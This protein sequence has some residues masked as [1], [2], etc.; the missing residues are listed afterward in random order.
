M[1]GTWLDPLL[2]IN[3][4]LRFEHSSEDVAAA[5]DFVGPVDEPAEPALA[6]AIVTRVHHRMRVLPS[7]LALGMP[8]TLREIVIRGGGNCVSHAVLAAVLLRDRGLPTRLIVEDVY[9]NVSLLRAPAALLPARVGPTLNGHVWI[10]VCLD[11]EWVPADPE[12]G[13]FGIAEWFAARLA[14]GSTLVALGIPV[15][16]HWK[17][18]LRIR[19]LGP[20]GMPQEDVTCLHLI[21][22]LAAA[23]GPAASL[24]S[25]W[26]EGVRYFSGSC[27]W[28]GWAGLR[29]LQEGRRLRQMTRALAAFAGALT[30]E[31]V[32]PQE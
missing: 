27:R 19:R 2:V 3:R 15:R 1:A 17:F 25:A 22:R 30:A 23:V 26:V 28:D 5:R 14:R 16:E 18:P 9:T 11:D 32:P 24:P 21:D 20:D 8:K 29:L 4:R 7:A 13:A 31:R 10:E 6:R 12:L